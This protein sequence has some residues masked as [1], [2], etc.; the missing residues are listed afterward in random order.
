[1]TSRP[2]FDAYRVFLDRFTAVLSQQGNS[3][4]QVSSMGIGALAITDGLPSVAA[5]PAARASAAV[6]SATV[7]PAMAPTSLSSGQQEARP[8]PVGPLQASGQSATVVEIDDDGEEMDV[9]DSD[10]EMTDVVD[11]EETG[12]ADDGE[13]MGKVDEEMYDIDLG[14]Q[15][16]FKDRDG[17]LAEL[18]GLSR[19]FP[20]ALPVPIRVIEGSPKLCVTLQSSNRRKRVAYMAKLAE[21]AF[22][23]AERSVSRSAKEPG[24][25]CKALLREQERLWKLFE[26]ER[27]RWEVASIEES[28]DRCRRKIITYG[29][30]KWPCLRLV[31]PRNC[32]SR[33]ASCTSGP[34]SFCHPNVARDIPPRSPYTP[35]T[36]VR[37]HLPTGLDRG[38]PLR[39]PSA[40]FSSPGPTSLSPAACRPP[41][42]PVAG[43]FRL[44]ATPLAGPSPRT[45]CRAPSAVLRPS[46]PVAGPS[47]LPATPSAALSSPTR[48]RPT[49]VSAQED[50]PLTLPPALGTQSRQPSVPPVTGLSTPAPPVQTPPSRSSKGK[51]KKK[52]VQFEP[53]VVENESTQLPGEIPPPLDHPYIS[54]DP[55]IPEEEKQLAT[56][57]SLIIGLTTQLHANRQDTAKL[58]EYCMKLVSG[59]NTLS[60]T[61]ATLVNSSDI[62]PLARTELARVSQELMTDMNDFYCNLFDSPFLLNP[63]GYALPPTLDWLRPPNPARLSSQD[64]AFLDI[65]ALPP[66]CLRTL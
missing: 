26:D 41:T 18:G 14:D 56:F 6:P 16:L 61:M 39:S 21:S 57:C 7:S 12:G 66:D 5:P 34:C 4:R 64:A 40:N 31:K 51:G 20:V 25:A 48:S 55:Q 37:R 27:E 2:E 23:C 28:C 8:A 13:R 29:R 45:L 65:L 54:N 50:S 38:Y 17:W 19:T 43:P 59:M 63:I 32:G 44:P 22:A 52:T 47:R 49:P 42:S 30:K 36:A 62:G 24:S 3:P 15:E 60:Q 58:L 35:S 1:M 33:C 9:V 10:E 11:D 46:T 53:A